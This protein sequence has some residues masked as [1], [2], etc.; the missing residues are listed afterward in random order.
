MK[1]YK[2]ITRVAGPLVFVEKTEPIGYSDLVKISP[3]ARI[4]DIVR[5]FKED[6]IAIVAD[7]NKFYGLITQIDL[8]NHLRKAMF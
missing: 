8:I 2:T 6:K 3:D 5:V 7:D 1:E 4:D